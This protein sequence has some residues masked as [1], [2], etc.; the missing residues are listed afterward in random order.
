MLRF[1]FFQVRLVF[2]A[3]IFTCVT[4][5]SFAQ[6]KAVVKEFTVAANGSADFKTIQEA[7]NAVRDHLQERFII[8]VKPGIYAEKLV[9]PAWKKHIAIVGKDPKTTIITNAD[10][11]GKSRLGP[12]L[13]GSLKFSTYTSFTVM[14]AGNDCTLENLTI[15]NTAGRVGQAVALA[16]EGNRFAAKN[17]L[18]LGNQDTL[19]TANEG[20]NYFEDCYISGTTDFIFGEATA[21]FKDC[22]IHSLSNSYITAASTPKH[23][24]YGYVFLN[25]KLTAED[26]VSKVYLGRPWRP[27]AKTVFMHCNLGKHILSEGW[28]AWPGDPIFV[29]KEKTA[30]YAEFENTGAGAATKG[31][32]SWSKQLSKSEAKSY[33]T[34]LIFEGWIPEFVLK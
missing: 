20:K 16:I 9:V 25:C 34:E 8:Y 14:I 31:R 13:T 33:K 12:D 24:K 2:T 15:Q 10:F 32:V 18:I 3:I 19:Y 28:N 4:A 29:E 11:S 21:I 1:S 22:E 27:F 7:V 17:C 30:Y 26:N 6:K 23:S 5:Q